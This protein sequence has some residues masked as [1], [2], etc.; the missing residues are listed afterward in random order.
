MTKDP[1]FRQAQMTAMQYPNAPSKVVMTI[2]QMT[3][4]NEGKRQKILGDTN[5]HPNKRT[6]PSRP[7][8]WTNNGP[9][10]KSSWKP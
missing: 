3:K 7:S 5:L 4:L 1:L 2:Y 9:S 10:S 8:T 6:R